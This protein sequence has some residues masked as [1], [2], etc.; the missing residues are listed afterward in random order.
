MPYTCS[1]YY[2]T[3]GTAGVSPSATSSFKRG[4][5]KFS[6][7]V[8]GYAGCHVSATAMV[9][10]LRDSENQLLYSTSIAPRHAPYREALSDA[11]YPDKLILRET[12]ASYLPALRAANPPKDAFVELL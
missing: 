8:S 11:C 4:I 12:D 2:A 5:T 3:T 10:E 7:S 9:C 1:C 6:A